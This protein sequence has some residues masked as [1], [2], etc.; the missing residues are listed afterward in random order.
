MNTRAW[1]ESELAALERAVEI[2]LAPRRRDGSLRRPTTIWIVTIGDEA[3]VRSQNGRAGSWYRS[4]VDGKPGRLQAGPLTA[5][6]SFAPVERADD[7]DAVTDA[8]LRKY[9]RFEKIYGQPIITPQSVSATLRV[10]PV[11]AAPGE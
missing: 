9:G 7:L 10:M 5:D 11:S 6:V 4:A 1:T 2:S 8:Y 3:F